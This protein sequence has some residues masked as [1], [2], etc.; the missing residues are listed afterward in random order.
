MSNWVETQ[1]WKA[2]EVALNELRPEGVCIDA[3]IGD[4]DYYFEWFANMGYKVVAIDPV[5]SEYIELLCNQSKATLYKVALGLGSGVAT[6]HYSHDAQ[7]RSLSN[8]WG[9]D[10][11]VEVM[12]I[13]LPELWAMIEEPAIAALKLDIEGVEPTI[14]QQLQDI[15]KLPTVIAFEIGGV[16]PFKTGLGRW[17]A[18][19]M[20][21]LTESIV[22]L[23]KLGYTDAQMFVSG[24]KDYA[25]TM[26]NG[27]MPM[28][29]NDAEWGN[30]V[31]VRRNNGKS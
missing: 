23:W 7:I 2:I 27:D 11:A 1:T 15:E 17:N 28:I 4:G 16:Y 12:T 31:F 9:N 19:A 5:A 18:T 14:I 20:Y 8:V 29:P 25:F 30:M 3:G 21:E 10:N 26:R 13:S 6:L 22:L 24:E